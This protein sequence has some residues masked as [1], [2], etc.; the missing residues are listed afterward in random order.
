[1][2]E[3]HL[4]KS[5]SE[6]KALLSLIFNN[7][8]DWQRRI[9]PKGWVNSE[10]I[11]LLH[12]TPQQQQK[13][14]I[15]I[16]DNLNKLSK[17]KESEQKHLDISEFKQD[18]LTEISEF[19]EFQFILGLCVYDIFSNNHEVI[20]DDNK[21]YDLGSMRGSGRFIAEFLNDRI[22]NPKKYDYIDFYMGTVWIE[23]RGNLIPFYEFVFEKLKQAS[24]D[25]KYSFPK[26]MLIDFNE[27]AD[28][29]DNQNMADYRPEQ[30]LQKKFE[31]AE[32]EMQAKKIQDELDKAYQEEYEEAKYK[33]LYPIVQAYKNIYGVLPYGHPQKEFE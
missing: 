27:N 13:E 21:V 20:G 15:T 3:N 9:A 29:S 17:K 31:S 11:F 28:P 33:P 12:P 5:D 18:D 4:N 30:A 23:G 16:T 10:Y 32:K 1:M 6:C 7:A 8:P 24:C 22:E 19:E 25:W 14:H 26:L 2:T